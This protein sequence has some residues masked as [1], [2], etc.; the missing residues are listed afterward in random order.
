MDH[1]YALMFFVDRCGPRE[2]SRAVARRSLK[3]FFSAYPAIG[4]NNQV[5][6]NWCYRGCLYYYRQPRYVTLTAN[7]APDVP[8][9]R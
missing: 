3:C 2:V 6:K 9:L 8:F 7:V 4:P 1:N 5:Q